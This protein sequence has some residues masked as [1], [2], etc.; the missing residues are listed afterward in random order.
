MDS[1]ADIDLDNTMIRIGNIDNFADSSEDISDDAIFAIFSL[2]CFLLY[3]KII[4]LKRREMMDKNFEK[5]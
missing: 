1:S 4:C 3:L 2:K 5:Q